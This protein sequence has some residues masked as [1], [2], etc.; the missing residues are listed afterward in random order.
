AK[1]KDFPQADELVPLVPLEAERKN[2]DMQNL[3]AQRKFADL[4][5]R[6]GDEDLAQRS[7]TSA[8]EA[9]F[10]R[11]RAYAASGDKAKAEADFR[12]ALPLVADK[13]MR[14]DLLKLLGEAETK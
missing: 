2:A 9:Y 10:A 8:G 11:G 3:L 14:A 7:F 5:K 13:R 6:Y 12:A 1:L 4:L